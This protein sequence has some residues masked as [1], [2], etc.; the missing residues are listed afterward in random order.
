MY[1]YSGKH[2]NRPGSIVGIRL[3]CLYKIRVKKEFIGTGTGMSKTDARNCAIKEVVR[4]ISEKDQ[5]TV[6]SESV[7]PSAFSTP[8][9][10]LIQNWEGMK[11]N[12]TKKIKRRYAK[13]SFLTDANNNIDQDPVV[14]NKVENNNIYKE[15][16]RVNKVDQKEVVDSEYPSE[17][18]SKIRK[19]NKT[20]G[21]KVHHHYGPRV[22]GLEGIDKLIIKFVDKDNA[23]TTLKT[24]AELSY[25]AIELLV[26]GFLLKRAEVQG[27]SAQCLLK[28]KL[29]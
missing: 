8:V 5:I 12:C 6:G 27:S 2:N 24:S 4:K 15:P 11:K 26:R 20:K 22:S 16:V 21:V 13:K 3:T 18:K 28:E 1:N 17:D 7:R 23:L 19:A 29:L 9:V 10:E 14:V 25:V